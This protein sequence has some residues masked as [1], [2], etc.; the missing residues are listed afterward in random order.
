[1]RIAYQ[2]NKGHTV[3]DDLTDAEVDA[4]FTEMTQK[5]YRGF[6]STG[7]EDPV[8]PIKSVQEARDAQAEE[9]Y[10]IAPLVGG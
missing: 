9:I 7:L 4:K 8:G 6:A 3:L 10:M 1:M 2:S 5:G